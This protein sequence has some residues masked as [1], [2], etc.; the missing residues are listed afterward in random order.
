M[1][2]DQ[3]DA[4]ALGLFEGQ[5]S[6]NHVFAHGQGELA[7]RCQVFN[8]AFCEKFLRHTV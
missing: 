5:L 6:E 4:Q 7:A 3:L 2:L 8:I 1:R